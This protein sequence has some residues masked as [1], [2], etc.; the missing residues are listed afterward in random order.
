MLSSLNAHE[1]DS[2]IKFF[3]EG[4]VYEL[5]GNTDCVSTTT[6]IHSFFNEFDADKVAKT[7]SEKYR[8]IDGH[9]YYGMSDDDIKRSWA[10]NNAA[11]EG[12]KLHADIEDHINGLKTTNES[13]E[14]GYFLTFMKD[15]PQY[16]PYRTEWVIFD[17]ALR[18]TGSIDIVFEGSAKD[19]VVLGDWKRS[20]EIKF[21]N[22]FSR[23]K[24]GL[25]HVDDCNF[26]HYCLQLNV[27]R[28]VLEKYYGK[29]VEEMFLVVLHPNNDGY[30]KLNVPRIT[31]DIQTILD[32]RA[33]DIGVENMRHM[34]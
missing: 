9:K 11:A 17:D 32:R 5:D 33:A 2:R 23:G 20:K 18:I 15:N 10:S 16:K 12:T 34:I 30:V 4:H 14:F 22:R 26:N 13:V 29:K 21:S 6:H 8:D 3:E 1:R 7:L 31:D 28:H 19:S 25:E 24:R 27:Y